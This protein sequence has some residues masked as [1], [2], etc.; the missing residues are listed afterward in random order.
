L[1]RGIVGLGSAEDGGAHELDQFIL[2]DEREE[3]DEEKYSDETYRQST[4][5]VANGSASR[6]H[7]SAQRDTNNEE[8]FDVGN[9]SDEEETPARRN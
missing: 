3:D 7:E 5:S 1:Q 9:E 2:R 8:I 4:N 6:P